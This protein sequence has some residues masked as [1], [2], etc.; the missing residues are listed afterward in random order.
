MVYCASC[1]LFCG[2]PAASV[3]MIVPLI[4]QRALGWFLFV[5]QACLL[6]N[7][8]CFVRHNII[9]MITKCCFILVNEIGIQVSIEE[10]IDEN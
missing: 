5:K 6:S 10:K 1:T 2:F 4:L 7:V 9:I 3:W 8:F